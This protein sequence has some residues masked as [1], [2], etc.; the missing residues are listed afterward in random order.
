LIVTGGVDA[1]RR[2]VVPAL[3]W[4]IERLAG[5]HDLHVFA[6][7]Y[8]AEPRSY[9]LLGATVHDIGRVAAPPGLR[10]L[11][12]LSRL[13]AAVERTGP[14]DVLHGY[15]GMPASIAASVGRRLKVPVVITLDSGEL[16]SLPDIGY[17]LQRR[18]IDRRVVGR[19][20]RTASR[21]TVCTRYMALMP[22]LRGT[23]VDIV[24]IGVEPRLFPQSARLDGPSWRLLRVASLNAVKDY[25]T[26]LRAL[27]AVIARM[28]AVHL[29]VVGVDT[30]DGAVQTLARD[31]G[32]AEHVSFHGFQPTEALAGFYARAHLHV[33]SSRHEAASVAV[34]EAAAAGV[35]TVGTA[36]GYVADWSHAQRAVAVPIGNHEALS[37]A[38][39]DLLN[40]PDRARDIAAAARAWAIEHDADYTAAQFDRLY[41]QTQNLKLET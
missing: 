7:H 30:L 16:V 21:I 1:A 5:R 37:A 32:V 33:V 4:L 11:A 26:L 36:V 8:Y 10:R 34:L 18:W 15:L 31:F 25:P 39:V 14:F 17:G 23:R 40:A 19:A 9:R 12:V 13:T 27:S 3:L 29:D 20:I 22:G 28:P 41:Q 6:L 38:I 24:P 35:P 2:D